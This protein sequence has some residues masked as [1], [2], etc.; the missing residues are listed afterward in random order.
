M[1][2]VIPTANFQ[3]GEAQSILPSQHFSK[4]VSTINGISIDYP[5][6]WLKK[7]TG[8]PGSGQGPENKTIV[9]F[10]P[11]EH[12]VIFRISVDR[13]P[14]NSTLHDVI[15]EEL[16]G[17][18]KVAKLGQNL[19]IEKS[20]PTILARYPAYEMLYSFG[21]KFLTGFIPM[22]AMVIVTVVNDTK[23]ATSYAGVADEFLSKKQ[24]AD[25]MIGSLQIIKSG[26]P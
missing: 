26:N 10:T 1:L 19:T 17:I 7:D 6:D 13:L 23:Y 24:L 20:I 11:P 16:K 15:G 14:T 2:V 3:H 9:V 21:Q 22:K 18:S 25:S 8:L 12:G 4:Y 5:L